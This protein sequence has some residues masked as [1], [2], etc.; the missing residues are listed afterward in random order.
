M[1]IGIPRV[2]REPTRQPGGHADNTRAAHRGDRRHAHAEKETMTMLVYRLSDDFVDVESSIRDL[3]ADHLGV[4]AADLQ[5]S[6]SLT[7][8]LAADSLDLVEIALAIETNLGVVLPRHFLDEVRTCGELIDATVALAR[9]R[10]TVI[11]RDDER[12]VALRAR[13]TPADSDHPWAVERV[14]LLTPYAA[15][16]LADDALRA[17]AGAHL[18]LRVAPRASETVISRIRTLFSS[19]NERGIEVEV[20]R[21]GA[22]GRPAT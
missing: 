8:D 4:G 11:P 13:L 5:R 9:R 19:L 17:G 21:D 20:R 10:P 22:A 18:E 15:E 12:P 2:P 7:D 16:S 14:L 3:V 1:M 6:T